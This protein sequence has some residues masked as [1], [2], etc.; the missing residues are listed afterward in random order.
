MGKRVIAEEQNNNQRST[1]GNQNLPREFNR[2]I[3]HG[4]RK[5][6]LFFI[7]F[8]LIILIAINLALTLWILKALE[9]SEVRKE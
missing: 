9:I 3:L 8:L 1:I 2:G 4:W 7:V 5:Y 6:C